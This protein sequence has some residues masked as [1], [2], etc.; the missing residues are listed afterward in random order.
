M[1]RN[2]AQFESELDNLYNWTVLQGG[3][4]GNMTNSP[5]TNREEYFAE[6]FDTYY[7]SNEA[8]AR[9]TQYLPKAPAFAARFL[10]PP[11]KL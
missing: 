8:R 11:S 5:T 4:S 2:H 3:E 10:L 7:C 9:L 1:Q 6:L